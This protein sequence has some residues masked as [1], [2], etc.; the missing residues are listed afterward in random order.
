ML[1]CIDRTLFPICCIEDK[2]VFAR[3]LRVPGQ[4]KCVRDDAESDVRIGLVYDLTEHCTTASLF[5]CLIRL[6]CAVSHV[7]DQCSI[8]RVV[9]R[10]VIGLMHTTEHDIDVRVSRD[11]IMRLSVC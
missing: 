7:A 8:T 11:L 4:A 2:R 9:I 6:V 10:Y 5:V 1:R 3:R